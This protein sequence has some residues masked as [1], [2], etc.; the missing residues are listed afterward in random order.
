MFKN[1][2]VKNLYSQE[3][4]ASITRK[5]DV[6]QLKSSCNTPQIAEQLFTCFNFDGHTGEREGPE[7]IP[8]VLVILTLLHSNSAYISYA[9]GRAT[10]GQLSQRP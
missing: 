7:D 5:V 3:C 8:V 6:K 1:L 9:E 4:S 2:S 10:L